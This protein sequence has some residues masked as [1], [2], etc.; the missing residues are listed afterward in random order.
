MIPFLFYIPYIHK[1][2]SYRGSSG[3][4]RTHQVSTPTTTLSSFKVA[5]AGRGAAF[6]FRELVTIHSNAHAASRLAPVKSGLAEDI[7]DAL[8]LGLA[9][10]L[11]GAWDDDCAYFGGNV[12]A[13]QIMC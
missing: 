1:V 6:A 7:G 5:V 8:F 4:S 12:L 2:S 10:H 9:A 13:F 11:H 3:H